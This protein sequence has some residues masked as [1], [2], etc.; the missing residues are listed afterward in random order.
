MLDNL[1]IVWTSIRFVK[2]A[3]RAG[4]IWKMTTICEKSWAGLAGKQKELIQTCSS[5]C[6]LFSNMQST[7][8]LREGYRISIRRLV[9]GSV[10]RISICFQIKKLPFFV[11]GQVK[12]NI[13]LQ[14]NS[15]TRTF[16]FTTQY[17]LKL[18]VWRKDR[19]SATKTKSARART[20]LASNYLCWTMC[21][22]KS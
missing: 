22:P 12:V 10:A 21:K 18:D 15:K 4:A 11:Y 3:N 5:C 1:H 9:T 7:F 6:E 16:T 8:C 14:L 13:A 20:L 2:Y 19:D 17:R